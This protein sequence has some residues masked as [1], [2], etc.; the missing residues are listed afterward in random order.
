MGILGLALAASAVAPGT[1]WA[2]ASR[3]GPT[4]ALGGPFAP[5]VRFPDV[6][7]DPANDVYLAISGQG[8]IFGRF[9][10]GDGTILGA[11]RFRI[12][13]TGAWT[14]TPSV[15]Y[16]PDLGGFLVAWLDNRVD[17]NFT[18]VWGRL[19]RYDAASQGPTYASADF[20]IAAP[21]GGSFSESPPALAY[22]TVSREFLVGWR[23]NGDQINGPKWDIRAR[24]L[25]VLG[26]VPTL[27]GE[28]INVTYDNHW[29]EDPQVAYDPLTDG[30]FLA[31]QNWIGPDP[32]VNGLW[33]RRVD[34]GTGALGEVRIL[35]ES[36][37]RI[38]MPDVNYNSATGQFLV[39]WYSGLPSPVSYGQLVNG[40]GTFTP[41]PTAIAINYSGAYDSLSVAYNAVSNTFFAVFHGR[42]P[43]T[44]PQED[45]GTEAGPTGV[46]LEP[47][48]FEV[49][50][51]GNLVGNYNPRITAHTSRK[52]WMMVT[53]T[54]FA[55]LSGQRIQTLSQAGNPPPPPPPPPP[56]TTY[57][58]TARPI[59]LG[60]ASNGSWYLAEGVVNLGFQGGMNTYY[61]VVNENDA[62]VCVRVTLAKDDGPTTTTTYQIAED[63][64]PAEC[65]GSA[66]AVFVPARTRK[67]Y[68]LA[69]F[70]GRD[71]HGS[72]GA[73]FQSMTPGQ[74][75]YVSRSVFW[76]PG[77]DSNTFEVAAET[78][79]TGWFFAE[80]V[81]FLG[82]D[83]FSTFYLLFNPDPS[84]V[85]ATVTATY[86]LDDGTTQTR[87]YTVSS[88]Q[89]TTVHVNATLPELAGHAFSV[90]FASTLPIVAERA[91]YFGEGGAWTGGHASMG[92]PT[93]FDGQGVPQL[94]TRY[95]FAE[96]VAATGFDTFYLLVNPH[97]SPIDV[98]VRYLKSD[99]TSETRTVTVGANRRVTV[100]LNDPAMNG[101]GNVGSVAAEFTSRSLGFAAEQSLYWGQ[102]NPARSRWL[103]WVEGSNEVGATAPALVWH[104]PEGSELPNFDTYLLVA[105]PNPV[106]TEV[107]IVLYLQDGTRFTTSRQVI[108]ANQRA[109][110]CFGDGSCPAGSNPLPVT[111][112][113][114]VNG[115]S[116]GIMVRSIL[117]NVP[118][119]A[120][121]SLY[122][123][124]DGPNYW[125]AGGT[126]LGIPK[127]Q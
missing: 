57:T 92:I 60:D 62:G 127:A 106:Q 9:V 81:R 71:A 97:A 107:D 86:Y 19:V 113:P 118:V 121:M 5:P 73:V 101:L 111:D 75:I 41:A 80:G 31:W 39:T 58:R 26:G 15:A 2:Q 64:V 99:G 42:A 115:K 65:V 104:F 82:S 16:S 55:Q 45:V 35:A 28:E 87:T 125:R 103:S 123:M 6:A 100:H 1:A 90:K 110:F 20:L 8:T 122:R 61:Q 48:D 38:S 88:Q 7:Y 63:P 13:E 93:T 95:Y 68:S 109:T 85:P 117:P 91:L 76:G 112:R 11:D 18:Q 116:F 12:P 54:G 102:V 72:Y 17:P 70:V 34:A 126:A 66:G 119:I 79:S 43:N 51:T 53:S 83:F 4:M 89:R 67:T 24:R 77:A 74:Q 98:D 124:W 69:D 3:V 32:G 47:F 78:L 56:P 120:Q 22:S 29:Q 37:G 23:Q 21:I 96:G 44:L 25:S 33:A 105:N 46:P 108:G 59:S 36:A 114:L 27:L 49:T 94:P 52:E 30:F 50:S 40:N 84:G 10:R 14:Q